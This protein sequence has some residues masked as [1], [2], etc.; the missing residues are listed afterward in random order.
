MSMNDQLAKVCCNR[1]AE[2]LGTRDFTEHAL[3]FKALSEPV[4]VAI[5]NRLACCGEANV[6]QIVEVLDL[7]QPTVS[8]HLR[9]LREAGLVEPE[10]R[11]TSMYYRL[12]PE[13]IDELRATI[14]S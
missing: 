10:R 1:G 2:P 9:I 5:V 4:R 8:H 3:R 11:G 12:C 13:A 14:A 6:C 7:A